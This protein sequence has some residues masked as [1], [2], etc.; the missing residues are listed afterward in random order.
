[1][2]STGV[3]PTSLPAEPL[4]PSVEGTGRPNWVPL[5]KLY[6]LHL[7]VFLNP[8]RPDP[9]TSYTNVPCVG[10]VCLLV[11]LPHHVQVRADKAH[12]NGTT[13]ST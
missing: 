10:S 11:R 6:T 12:G 4:T 3:G 1:M 2:A 7:P 8:A 5:C 9:N 13:A